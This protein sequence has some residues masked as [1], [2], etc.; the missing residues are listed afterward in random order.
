MHRQYVVADIGGAP[1]S[2]AGTRA[3]VLR[4]AFQQLRGRPARP[5]SRYYP[6]AAPSAV[7]ADPLVRVQIVLPVSDLGPC[8]LTVAQRKSAAENWTTVRHHVALTRII[9]YWLH[10][11]YMPGSKAVRRLS[12]EFREAAKR[13]SDLE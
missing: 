9:E 12:Q 3:R 1:R 6:H 5:R 8:M 10:I 13:R 2:P 11:C 4:R 7:A